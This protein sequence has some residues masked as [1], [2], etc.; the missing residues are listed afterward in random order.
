MKTKLVSI[1]VAAGALLALAGC[2]KGSAY[3][4]EA[5]HAETIGGKLDAVWFAR[6]IHNSESGLKAVELVYCPMVPDGPTVCR[7]AVIWERDKSELLE[8][9]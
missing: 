8:K 5:K 1:A 7:T 6:D 9:K 2:V 4:V 3:A